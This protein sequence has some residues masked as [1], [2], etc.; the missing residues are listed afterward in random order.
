MVNNLVGA[1]LH[2]FPQFLEEEFGAARLYMR[3]TA[4]PVVLQ[5]Q[6]A[7]HDVFNVLFVAKTSGYF[8]TPIL[9]NSSIYFSL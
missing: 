2:I 3:D 8:L 1:V 7:Q 4:N 6:D 9:P 5:L